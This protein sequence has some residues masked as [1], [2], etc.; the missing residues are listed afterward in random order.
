MRDLRAPQTVENAEL[1]WDHKLDAQM[2]APKSALSPTG[3]LLL[4]LAALGALVGMSVG[5]LRG[6]SS[7]PAWGILGAVLPS[8]VWLAWLPVRLGREKAQRRAA[9]A[10]KDEELERRLKE[11]RASGAFDKWEKT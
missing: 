9:Q 2:N 11:A 4:I 1:R 7:V 6:G 3:S 8:V 5:F 10:D